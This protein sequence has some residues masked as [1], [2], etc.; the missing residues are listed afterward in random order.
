MEK[1]ELLFRNFTDSNN[2]SYKMNSING[3][4]RILYSVNENEMIEYSQE[5]CKK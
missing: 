2:F 5:V 1:V 4:E 3:K